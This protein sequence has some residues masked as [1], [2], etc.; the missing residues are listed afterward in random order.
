[1]REK[2]VESYLRKKCLERGWLCEKFIPDNDNGMPD[3]LVLLPDGMVAWVELKTDDGKLSE[4]QKYQHKKLSDLGQLVFVA[5]NRGEVDNAVSEIERIV[6]D[7]GK[8]KS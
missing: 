8:G 6:S 2:E 5:W 4:L 7:A 1:M 3:R